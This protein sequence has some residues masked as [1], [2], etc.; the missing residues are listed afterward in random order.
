MTEISIVT[1]KVARTL[2]E[3]HGKRAMVHVEEQVKAALKKAD[4]VAVKSWRYVG[5]EIEKLRAFH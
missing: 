5:R 1:D 2:F 3:R 4:W